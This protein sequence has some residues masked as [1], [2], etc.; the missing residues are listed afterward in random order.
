[1]ETNQTAHVAAPVHVEIDGKEYTLGRLTISDLVAIQNE[2]QDEIIKRAQSRWYGAPAEIV[3]AKLSDAEAKADSIQV[4]TAEFDKAIASPA[5]L[6]SVLYWSMR[7]FKPEISRQ[8]IASMIRP[9]NLPAILDK[10]QRAAGLSNPKD[11]GAETLA[12][13]APD[14]TVTDN[15]LYQ[16]ASSTSN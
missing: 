1:M 9:D 16:S 5:G 8:D 11:Q 13:P 2:L 3:N 12:T 7:K 14:G 10:M 15:P 4:G 6:V